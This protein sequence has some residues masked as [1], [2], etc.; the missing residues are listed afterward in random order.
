M[1]HKHNIIISPS[2]GSSHL[3]KYSCE[4]AHKYLSGWGTSRVK[5]ISFK[6]KHYFINLGIIFKWQLPYLHML[7]PFSDKFRELFS[8]SK[9]FLRTATSWQ[10][11]LRQNSYLL[12]A[13]I[14]SEQPHFMASYF[15][16]QSL[17]HLNYLVR[18]ATFSDQKLY[19]AS[20]LWK[21]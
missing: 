11:L 14:S 18:I 17:L 20:T 12:R 6:T 19:R 9:H 3:D 13:A 16:E 10:E 2:V 5:V 8:R 4:N 21:S 15:L 1:W 7:W